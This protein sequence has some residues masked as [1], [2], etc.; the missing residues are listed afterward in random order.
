MPE[1]PRGK[2]HEWSPYEISFILTIA[3]I[4]TSFVVFSI[5]A[6]MQT[7]DPCFSLIK[8]LRWIAE[9]VFYYCRVAL[10]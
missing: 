6:M 9:S 1:E 8:E 10:L 7:I 4:A 5:T 2:Q 3:M